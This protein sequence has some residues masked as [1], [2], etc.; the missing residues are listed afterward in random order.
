MGEMPDGRGADHAGVQV[1][2][3]VRD[4]HGRACLSGRPVW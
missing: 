2:R 4:P 3:Q 1:A